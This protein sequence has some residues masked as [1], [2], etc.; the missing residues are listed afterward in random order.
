ML[1]RG[2]EST[3]V[4]N[5]DSPF[6]LFVKKNVEDYP[7]V[8]QISVVYN[9]GCDKVAENA[10]KD[11]FDTDYACGGDEGGGAKMLLDINDPRTLQEIR[12]TEDGL[13]N[14]G[15]PGAKKFGDKGTFNTESFFEFFLSYIESNIGSKGFDPIQDVYWIHDK[16]SA[17]DDICGEHNANT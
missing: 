2:L 14:Y 6:Y 1:E 5:S 4:L 17:R 12:D 10:D 9:F 13:I 16:A 15:A 11:F 3:D 8:A 7:V